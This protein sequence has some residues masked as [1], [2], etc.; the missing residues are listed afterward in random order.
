[1]PLPQAHP[2]S[3]KK[4]L[5]FRTSVSNK[6]WDFFPLPTILSMLLILPLTLDE[7]LFCGFA[8][9]PIDSEDGEGILVFAVDVVPSRDGSLNQF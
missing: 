8:V 1:M 9:S 7:M 4:W 2:S 5:E 3:A 6:L